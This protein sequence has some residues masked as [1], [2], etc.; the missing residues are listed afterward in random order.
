MGPRFRGD[1]SPAY[2]AL[3]LKYGSTGPVSLM[4][5]GRAKGLPVGRAGEVTRPYPPL[6]GEGRIAAGDPG[7]GDLTSFPPVRFAIHPLPICHR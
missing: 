6:E 7:W 2:S 4:V 5:S 3:S 1:D